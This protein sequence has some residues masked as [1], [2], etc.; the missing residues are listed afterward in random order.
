M[1]ARE[2]AARRHVRGAGRRDAAGEPGGLP[3]AG[4]RAAGRR[5]R[6]DRDGDSRRA[7]AAQQQAIEGDGRRRCARRWRRSTSRSARWSASAARPTASCA[8]RCKA[9]TGDAGEA[10]RRDRQPGERAEGAGR[11]RALGR[12]AAAARRRAG[13]DARAL[14]LR[15]ADDGR[16][17]GRPPAPGHGR[18]ACRADG[19]IV[20]DAKAP[21]GAYLEA[22]EAP[23]DD[24]ARREVPPARRAGAR[25]HHEAGRQEL[26]GRAGRLAR[27]GRDVPA[28]RAALQR[29][30][31][32]DAGADGGGG[33]AEA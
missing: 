8:S 1:D 14:R 7:S 10:A 19:S 17:R 18:A 32:A 23:D 13:R 29:R 6:A 30:A 4:Q 16:R 22:R 11:A 9:M 28:R 15:A 12:D 5:A 27:H 24:D 31:G 26:L 2:G 25:A 33:R 21:L 20:V 3:G